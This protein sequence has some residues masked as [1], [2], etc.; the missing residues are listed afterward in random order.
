MAMQFDYTMMQVAFGDVNDFDNLVMNL[1]PVGLDPVWTYGDERYFRILNESSNANAQIDM[2]KIYDRWYSR[3]ITVEEVVINQSDPDP[4]DPVENNS[5]TSTEPEANISATWE[6]IGLCPEEIETSGDD[7]KAENKALVTTALITGLI[8]LVVG[9]VFASKLART[10]DEP[11]FVPAPPP[12]GP[13][14]SDD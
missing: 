14:P 3:D 1:Q 7:Q 10:E 8:L 9:L 12:M 4:P 6:C 2:S 11:S 13:P 5:N